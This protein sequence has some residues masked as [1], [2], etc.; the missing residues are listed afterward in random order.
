M[1]II[2][3]PDSGARDPP[4]HW[5]LSVIICGH[6]LNTI[7]KTCSISPVVF[8]LKGYFV[9]R[10]NLRLLGKLYWN[11]LMTGF[12]KIV[13]NLN[14]KLELSQDLPLCPFERFSIIIFSN[15]FRCFHSQSP[16][17]ISLGLLID[18]H[19]PVLHIFSSRAF[20]LVKPVGHLRRQSWKSL[21][22][23]IVLLKRSP[24]STPYRRYLQQG[25]A[26]GCEVE[27][28]PV[29]YRQTMLSRHDSPVILSHQSAPW[30][31]YL[32]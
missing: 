2:S 26:V 1:L 32:L 25:L 29:H 11:V 27:V 22:P 10:Q 6:N 24:I 17:V 4:S 21:W 14:C 7:D 12:Y 30:N 23:R 28:T 5:L 3:A 9:A 8:H 31:E 19:K 16:P 18:D 13:F 15:T 20:F